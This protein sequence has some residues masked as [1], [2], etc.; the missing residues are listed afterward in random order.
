MPVRLPW[1]L[2]IQARRGDV[3][4]ERL[5]RRGVFDLPLTEAVFRLVDPGDLV[6]DVGANIG[7]VTGLAALRAGREGKVIGF[8]PHPSLYAELTE[9][10]RQWSD[11]AALA[12]VELRQEAASDSNGTASLAVDSFDTN[13]GSASLRD[14]SGGGHE[15]PTVKL[16]TVL[17]SGR[18]DLLKVDV[19]GHELSVF[20]GASGLLSS[21]R[22][23]DVIF[24][25]ALEEY[26]TPVTELLEGHG[27]QL[28]RLGQSLFRPTLSENGS[29]VAIGHGDELNYLATREPDRVLSR[30]AQPGWR[31]LRRS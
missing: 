18:I 26:P 17:G 7:Y 4:G 8:E 10:V 20:Q 3:V 14:D 31:A 23:R 6:V 11:Q 19:E 16:D 15:V 1:R 28:F 29:P 21:G 27:Y 9:T 12:P 13:R 24:E 25:E 2:S 30:Y 5:L 22:I